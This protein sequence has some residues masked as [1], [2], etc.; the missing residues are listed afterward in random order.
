[1]ILTS[2]SSYGIKQSES[3]NRRFRFF[4][5]NFHVRTGP[6]KNYKN[7][8]IKNKKIKNWQLERKVILKYIFKFS[9]KI[10]KMEN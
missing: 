5:D 8:K 7:K 4:E 1:M 9:K 10:Q 6:Q 3:K 2:N